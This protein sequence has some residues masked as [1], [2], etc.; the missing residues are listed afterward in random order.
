MKATL[1][2]FPKCAKIKY[3]WHRNGTNYEGVIP[4]PRNNDEF[5]QILL[6]RKISVNEVTHITV[7]ESNTKP[8]TIP[9]Q[10]K[11]CPRGWES[12]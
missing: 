9:T 6:S 8:V 12:V 4:T 5:Q 3:H 2:S 7:Y 10:N 11:P 1:F